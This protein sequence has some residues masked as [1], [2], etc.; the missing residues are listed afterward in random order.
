M[1]PTQNA[2]A[3]IGVAV[4][5]WN[6]FDFEIL[7]VSLKSAYLVDKIVI[8][9]V[10]RITIARCSRQGVTESVV[11]AVESTSLKIFNCSTSIFFRPVKDSWNKTTKKKKKSLQGT[12]VFFELFSHMYS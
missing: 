1:T 12:S 8:P 7:I 5:S 9:H 3:S 4:E 10:V 11:V 6:R 2:I